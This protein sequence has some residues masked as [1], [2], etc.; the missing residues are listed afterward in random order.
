MV[1]IPAH[2]EAAEKAKIA[3]LQDF[4]IT[5]VMDILRPTQVMPGSWTSQSTAAHPSRCV[6]WRK[7]QNAACWGDSDPDAS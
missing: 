6:P 3:A 1:D 5:A 7:V 2:A 4:F